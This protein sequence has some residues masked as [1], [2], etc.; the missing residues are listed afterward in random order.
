MEP[1]KIT[2]E[3][4]KCFLDHHGHLVLELPRSMF[5]IQLTQWTLLHRASALKQLSSKKSHIPP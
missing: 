4:V 2:I 1:K 3:S 5:G